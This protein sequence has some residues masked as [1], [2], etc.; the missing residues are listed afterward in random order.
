MNNG[1]N[2]FLINPEPKRGG[3]DNDVIPRLACPATDLDTPPAIE[4]IAS[5]RGRR[6]ARNERHSAEPLVLDQREPVA[7][8]FRRACVD[9]QRPRE[10]A[11]SLERSVATFGISRELV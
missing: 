7:G 11:K 1:A 6:L 2:I 5:E 9:N 4:R 10:M 3:R 8:F